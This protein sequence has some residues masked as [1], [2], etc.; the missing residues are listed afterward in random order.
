MQI[1]E[2]FGVS[3]V[4][5]ESLEWAVEQNTFQN[6]QRREIQVK[7]SRAEDIRTDMLRVRRGTTGGYQEEMTEEDIR[8]GAEMLDKHLDPLYNYS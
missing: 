3:S 8:Y 1:L 2:F 4:D 6:L 5:V 7:E